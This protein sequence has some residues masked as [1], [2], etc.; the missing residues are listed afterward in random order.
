MSFTTVTGDHSH[1]LHSL[2]FTLFT[3]FPSL[4]SLSSLHS[5]LFFPSLSSLPSPHS[6]PFTLFTLFP[7]LSSLSS[8]HS[9][10]SLPITLFPS[11]SSLSSLHSLHSLPSLL[12]AHSFLSF[13]LLRSFAYVFSFTLSTLC[14]LDQVHRLDYERVSQLRCCAARLPSVRSHEHGVLHTS[15]GRHHRRHRQGG[16]GSLPGPAWVP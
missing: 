1:S 9:L 15:A 5:L 12:F 4:S 3:L 11:L 13:F 6:L 2:P 8:L 16:Q 14:D 7:S 10:R